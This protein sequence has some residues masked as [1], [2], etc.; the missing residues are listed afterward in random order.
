MVTI[1]SSEDPWQW[2]SDELRQ[3]FISDEMQ[4]H[5]STRSELNL[6]KSVIYIYIY[7][8]F[9]ILYFKPY[10]ITILK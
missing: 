7:N 4:L 6:I 2:T 10:F 5:T 1:V 3:N 9:Y 8:L